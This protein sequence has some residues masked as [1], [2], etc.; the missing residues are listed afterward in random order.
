MDNSLASKSIS[1]LDNNVIHHLSNNTKGHII[2]S[3]VMYRYIYVYILETRA[4]M[5]IVMMII[6]IFV[7]VT[8]VIIRTISIIAT[9][10]HLRVILKTRVG[11]SDF[12]S[13]QLS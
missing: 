12:A 2:R 7:F 6:I 13:G 5:I 8:V 4:I 9:I 3:R 11:V 10:L 1:L